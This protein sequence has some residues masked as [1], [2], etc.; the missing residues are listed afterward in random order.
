MNRMTRRAGITAALATLTWAGF[1]QAHITLEVRKAPAG[2]TYKAVFRVPHGCSGSPTKSIEVQIPGGMINVK[3]MP[4]PGWQLTTRQGKLATPYVS[5]GGT[6]ITEGVIEVKWSGGPLP[7]DQYDEFVLRGMLPREPGRMLYFPVIQQCEKGANNWTAIP[8]AGKT[9]D[10]YP[11]P[12]PGL[13]LTAPNA[14]DR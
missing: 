13:M 6:T 7:D 11:E 3:P 1:A 12:A 5:E 10:D 2:S 9:A 4:H 8:A 14:G